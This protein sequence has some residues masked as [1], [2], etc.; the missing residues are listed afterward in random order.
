MFSTTLAG[1]IIAG[2][3]TASN[4]VAIPAH[5]VLI[6]VSYLTI[7]IGAHSSLDSEASETETVG[8]SEAAM[9]PVRGSMMLFGLYLVLM[10]VD[11]SLINMLLMGYITLI[12]MLVL[13]GMFTVAVESV[14]KPAEGGGTKVT[15]PLPAA[16]LQLLN[17]GEPV[18]FTITLA[19][20]V[21]FLAAAALCAW[22]VC[23]S[24]SLSSLSPKREQTGSRCMG[25]SPGS[26]SLYAMLF[27]CS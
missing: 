24:L 3:F 20:S 4:F 11:K 27:F 15:I 6:I 23:I 7:Y 8:T 19:N 1:L 21:S 2:L 14:L 25:A 18:S 26:V 9:L 16:M 12:A 13:T 5:T 10:L 22:C 17:D